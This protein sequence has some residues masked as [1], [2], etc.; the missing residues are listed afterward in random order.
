MVNKIG[1]VQPRG[2]DEGFSSR[3]CVGSRLRHETPE[4]GQRTYQPK[5]CEYNN[6]DVF[7]MYNWVYVG[8]LSVVFCVS[9]S[10]IYY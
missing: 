6:K 5:R 2:L 9:I 3:F 8:F 4:E 1:T 7:S 10:R